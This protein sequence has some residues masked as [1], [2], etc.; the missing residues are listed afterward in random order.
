MVIK[1]NFEEQFTIFQIKLEIQKVFFMDDNQDMQGTFM[2]T[3]MTTTIKKNF[4]FQV[5]FEIL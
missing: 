1:L 2:V 3:Y 5:L 4:V